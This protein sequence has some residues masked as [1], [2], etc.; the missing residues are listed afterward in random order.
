[1]TKQSRFQEELARGYIPIR[2]IRQKKET[3]P[4]NAVHR[5][6]P[7][8]ITLDKERDG[9][10]DREEESKESGTVCLCR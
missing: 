10:T 7:P 5:S 3:R 2:H 6:E 8:I 1:M 4:F 9:V